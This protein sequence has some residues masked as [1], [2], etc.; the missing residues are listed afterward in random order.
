MLAVY[1]DD[2][3]DYSTNGPTMDGIASLIYVLAAKRWNKR[4][5]KNRTLNK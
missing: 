3:G 4:G 5:R 2:Y 1:Q